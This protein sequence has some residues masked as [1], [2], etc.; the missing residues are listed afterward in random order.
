M[1]A[2][3][4]AW[5]RTIFPNQQVPLNR[6]DPV[7]TKFL[8]YTPWELPNDTPDAVTSASGVSQ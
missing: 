8:S 7:A 5:T 3:T 2:A 4:N 6:F 1:N